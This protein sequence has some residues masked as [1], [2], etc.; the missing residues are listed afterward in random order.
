LLLI[1]ADVATGNIS[2]STDGSPV[3]GGVGVGVGVG[4]GV[5]SVT[6]GAG[7]DVP[8]PEPHPLNVRANMLSDN[9]ATRFNT[10]TLATPARNRF[11]FMSQSKAS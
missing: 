6:G 4:A 5:G 11:E 2:R 3:G 1:W 10:S 7:F 8:P 9:G